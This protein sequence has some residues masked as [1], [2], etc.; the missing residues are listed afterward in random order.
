MFRTNYT[1]TNDL[2]SGIALPV[3]PLSWG[4]W[5]RSGGWLLAREVRR[6]AEALDRWHQRGRSRRQLMALDDRMLKDIGISRAEAE[7]EYRK[8]FWRT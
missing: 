8:P 3:P 5:L 4:E 7:A 1:H 6:G 2:A